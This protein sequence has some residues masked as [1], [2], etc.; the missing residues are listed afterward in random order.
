[1]M[2]EGM[3][4]IC[5]CPHHKVIPLLV[6][7]FGLVFLLK[8]LGFVGEGMVAIVWPTIVLIAG[9]MKATESY[10]KCCAGVNR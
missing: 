1:M 4:N 3:Q 5:R 7:L 9:L 2:D 6:A 10:C 8:G